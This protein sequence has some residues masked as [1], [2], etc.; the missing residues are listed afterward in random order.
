MTLNINS[1][2]VTTAQGVPI[3]CIGVA[4]V[5]IQGQS[6]EMLAAACMQFLGKKEREIQAIALETMEG[7]QRAIM[8]TMTV[9][10]IYQDRKKFAMTVSEVSLKDLDKMGITLISYTMK[11]V[12]DDEGYLKS[13]GMKRIAQVQ[14][15]A[16]VGQAFAKME[17]G[18][19]E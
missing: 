16:R 15:E 14:C 7:H 3:S 2:G 11:D 19:G 6:Q 12:S 5:K 1:S 13:L 9:E 10:E 18:I 8:G 17:S 4:Q